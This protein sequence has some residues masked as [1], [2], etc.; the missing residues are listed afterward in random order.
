MTQ[1]LRAFMATLMEWP[2]VLLLVV[3]A[4]V[5]ESVVLTI[6]QGPSEDDG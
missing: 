2:D 1:N 4:A 6:V 5:L 3:V